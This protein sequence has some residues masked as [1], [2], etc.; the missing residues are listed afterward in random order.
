MVVGQSKL[1]DQAASDALPMRDAFAVLFFVS[2]GMLF[3][4]RFLVQEP[5]LVASV[6]GVVLIAKPLAALAIVLGLGHSVTTALTVAIGLAQIGEFSFILA[7]AAAKLKILPVQGQSVLVAAALLSIAVNPLL[8]RGAGRIDQALRARPKLWQALNRRAE[9]RGRAAN[10]RTI[11]EEP[12]G[13]SAVLVGYGPVGMTVR[14]ILEG[15]KIRPRIV[16]L[17]VD[18]ILRLSEEGAAAIYGDASKLDILRAAGVEKAKYLIVTLPELKGRAPVI[19]A[20][21][22]LNPGILVLTRARYLNERGELE[23]LGASAACYEEAEAAVGLAEIL[24]QAE[25]A[26]PEKVEEEARRIR[27]ELRP[28]GA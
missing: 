25:G 20:A 8:F 19:S 2:V 1:S 9:I 24:L 5:L 18:T 17:N 16:D 3:D 28:R 26:P 6:L 14:R 22:S 21:K 12:E 7:D 23:R 27:A 13:V 10:Q 15:F 4:P 11:R